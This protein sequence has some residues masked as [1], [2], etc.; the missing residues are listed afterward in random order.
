M[1]ERIPRITRMEVHDR[2]QQ[3]KLE[4]DFKPAQIPLS[5]VAWQGVQL[6]QD[7][8]LVH[9]FEKLL[10]KTDSIK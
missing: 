1:Q 8:K 3:K 10:V 7:L 4:R 5:I 9:E 2:S 6:E